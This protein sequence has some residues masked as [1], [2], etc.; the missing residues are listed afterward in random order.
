MKDNN[1]RINVFLNKHK[2]MYYTVLFCVLFSIVFVLSFTVSKLIKIK[3]EEDLPKYVS[4]SNDGVKENTPKTSEE[5]INDNQEV[6]QISSNAEN[7]NNVKNEN[8][9]E[10]EKN[11]DEKKGE[12]TNNNIANIENNKKQEVKNVEKNEN[13]KPIQQAIETKSVEEKQESK[14]I[15]ETKHNPDPV[16]ETK[17]EPVVE[18]KKNPVP[19][20]RFIYQHNSSLEQQIIAT[21][22]SAI[23]ND[24]I[25]SECGTSV[26][27]GSKGNGQGFTYRG[28]YQMTTSKLGA[29]R[30]NFVYVE[31]EYSE[32]TD[33]S[34]VKTG[35]TLV[36]IY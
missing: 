31:D 11:S 33:G 18:E 8:E 12:E 15:V 28:M 4:T 20:G 10:I 24:E 36:Y 22:R 16:V 5:I 34:S 23:S 1:S 13:T 27:S 25:H 21:L 29:G 32:Y 3:K 19:T 9:L 30:Q 17:Q 26:T 35:N 2:R 6:Q 14:P 7:D